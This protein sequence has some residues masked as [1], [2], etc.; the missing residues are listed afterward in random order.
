M[1]DLFILD[2][3]QCFELKSNRNLKKYLR[4]NFDLKFVIHKLIGRSYLIHNS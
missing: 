2:I 4:C 1:F 3:I